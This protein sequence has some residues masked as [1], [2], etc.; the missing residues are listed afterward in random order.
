MDSSIKESPI[1]PYS[2]NPESPNL[3]TAIKESPIWSYLANPESSFVF[4]L[5]HKWKKRL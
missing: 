3:E 2:A 1:M 4:T 5:N